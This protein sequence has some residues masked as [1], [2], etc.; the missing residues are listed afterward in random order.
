MTGA[1]ADA[2]DGA[3]PPPASPVA[4]PSMTAVWLKELDELERG[5]AAER[6]VIGIVGTTGAGKSSLLN[7]LLG[8]EDLL[9][10]S[11]MHASTACA[12]EVSYIAAS[13]S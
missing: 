6:V 7:A 8:R 11:G 3:A 9:P 12:V 4:G 5:C 10:T 13:S 1:Q 2:I